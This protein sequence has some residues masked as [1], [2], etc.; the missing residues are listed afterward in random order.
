MNDPAAQWTL[1]GKLTEEQ[2][3]DLF[4]GNPVRVTVD[5]GELISFNLPGGT[6]NPENVERA[7]K[8]FHRAREAYFEAL[9][10]GA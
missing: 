2:R 9:A 7:R 10:K 8:N 1:V 3:M 6:A 5:A 4:L